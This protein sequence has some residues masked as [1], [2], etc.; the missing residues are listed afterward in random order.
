MLQEEQR[1][2]GSVTLPELT[3]TGLVVFP[4]VWVE[5]VLYALQCPGQGDATHQQDTEHHVRKQGRE[6]HHLQTA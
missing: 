5:V 2:R 3:Y 4:E 6:P 1:A